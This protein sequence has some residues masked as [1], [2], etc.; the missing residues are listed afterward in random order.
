MLVCLRK[1]SVYLREHGAVLT[2]ASLVVFGLMIACLTVPWFYW[3]STFALK[4]AVASGSG[5][6]YLAFTTLNSTTIMYDLFGSRTITQASGSIASFDVYKNLES[7]TNSNIFSAFK[8]SQACVLIA[9]I[10]SF[11]LPLFLLDPIRNWAIFA[12]G[13]ARIRAILLVASLLLVASVIVA[14][15][16][17]S[18]ISAAFKKD[19]SDCTEGSCRTFSGSVLS[20]FDSGAVTSTTAWGPHAGWYIAL[21]S[22]PISLYVIFLI[23]TLPKF[24]L[25]IEVIA[26]PPPKNFWCLKQED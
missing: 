5:T 11:S 12:V 8:L 26:A 2:R 19:Q 24:P 22:T 23:A 13:M 20:Q 4:A 3:S 21:A 9:L 1:N 16:G 6:T 15:W 7:S 17:F 14:F 18:G 10:L 25:P